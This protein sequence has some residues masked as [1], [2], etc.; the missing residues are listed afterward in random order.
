MVDAIFAEPRLAE[1][2]DFV[3][4]DRSDLGAYLAMVEE[5]DARSVI[6]VGCGTGTFAC[7]LAERSK[8]VTGVDPAAASIEVARRKPYADCVRWVV[9]DAGSLPA[10]QVDLVTMTGNVA[11]VFLSDEDWTGAL[12]AVHSVIR[13]GG[14]MIFEVRDTDRQAWLEWTRER[15]YR[16]IE[17][18]GIGP[19]QSWVELTEVDP[20]FVT[21]CWNFV[22]EADGA[23]LTSSSTLR[24]RTREEISASLEASG[25]SV[26]SVR[27]APDRPAREHVFVARRT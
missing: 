15:S 17:I 5:F 18:P 2:Y 3:D 8:T 9:G 16:R 27:D 6:D 22:F 4:S 1:V 12:Q 24:F 14:L 21:F 19:V 20:P 23:A 10:Q 26:E 13:P 25:F 7:L 11:Q